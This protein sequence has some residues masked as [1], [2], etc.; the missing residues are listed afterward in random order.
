MVDQ[1]DEYLEFEI[2]GRSIHI[3]APERKTNEISSWY[4]KRWPRRD[5]GGRWSISSLVGKN[6]HE[7]RPWTWEYGI[8]RRC[9]PW[10]QRTAWRPWIRK[11]RISKG[12]VSSRKH[13]LFNSSLHPVG[14]ENLWQLYDCWKKERCYM[15]DKSHRIDF[16]SQ[17]KLLESI[18]EGYSSRFSNWQERWKDLIILCIDC[19]RAWG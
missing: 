6:Y 15:I 19:T 18:Y 8:P 14:P 13:G 5:S 7:S 10:K 3:R 1:T 16:V 11:C 4:R 9:C 17:E 12:K 2:D